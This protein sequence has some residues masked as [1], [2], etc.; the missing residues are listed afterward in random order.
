MV[1][2]QLG[3]VTPFVESVAYILGPMF[4]IS[5]VYGHRDQ[6]SVPDS[7][8]PK[9]L[10][11]DFM[12][13]SVAVG[14]ALAGFAIANAKVLG[15]KY[16]VWN[17][18][19]WNPERG[20]WVAYTATSNPHTDHVHISF[21]KD[22]DSG[23]LRE[24][25]KGF[26]SGFS[27]GVVDSAQTTA[28]AITGVLRPLSILTDRLIAPNFWRRVAAGAI[29]TGF[30]I[31]GLIYLARR[32]IGAVASSVTGGAAQL[33]GT[34]LQGA[35]FGA[36][37]GISGGLGGGNRPVSAAPAA[38]PVTAPIRPGPNPPKMLPPSNA[39]TT[40]VLPPEIYAPTSSGGTY[41]VTTAKGRAEN[42]TEYRRP[43]GGSLIDIASSRNPAPKP[44]P[45]K[46]KKGQFTTSIQAPMRQQPYGGE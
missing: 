28:N 27:G 18:Q 30:I 26:T 41:T 9:G 36:G 46:S 21:K 29:G 6:G 33:A 25:A 20:T 15:V 19:S 11:L 24:F 1:S 22:A 43:K 37:A 14:D 7:D 4:G 40:S 8:H 23:P 2:Y 5:T 32:P 34:A 3:P 44:K 16:I 38:A 13:S 31:V 17:R 45:K 10:A 12:T 35:A 42:P 39:P